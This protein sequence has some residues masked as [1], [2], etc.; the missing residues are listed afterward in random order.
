ML[1]LELN[2]WHHFTADLRNLL[3]LNMTWYISTACHFYTEV[4]VQVND[5][6]ISR[7]CLL[8]KSFLFTANHLLADHIYTQ[9]GMKMYH[10]M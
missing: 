10:L 1:Y 9:T 3:L 7:I 5:M 8:V 6:L 4:I 2:A